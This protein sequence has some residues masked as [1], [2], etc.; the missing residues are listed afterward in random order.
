MVIYADILFLTNLY[1]D[2]FLIA[3]VKHF[4]NLRCTYLRALVGAFVG[5]VFSLT[6]LLPALHGALGLLLSIVAAVSIILSSFYPL[7]LHMA[8]KAILTYWSFSF[9]FAGFFILIH[10]LFSPPEIA[11]RNGVV[12]LNVS[13]LVLFGLTALAYIVMRLIR[14][15]TGKSEP[16]SLYC[17]FIAEENGERCELFGKSDS[18]HTLRE[19]FSGLPVMIVEEEAVSA[20]LPDPVKAYLRNEAS[21]GNNGLRLIP[22]SSIGGRGLLPAFRVEHLW[23]A[24]NK[25]PVSCYLAVCSCKLSSGQFN[26]LF[27]PSLIPQESSPTHTSQKKQYA[28]PWFPGRKGNGNGQTPPFIQRKQ[29]K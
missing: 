19:P 21:S 7:S 10:Q 17:R 28:K 8:I 24:K 27:E 20:L 18:G 2:F 3:C 15:I 11:V 26:A 23:I 12:Y 25:A 6:A 22:Y 1:I 14:Y 13:P 5:A 29:E 16:E 9:V 4:L